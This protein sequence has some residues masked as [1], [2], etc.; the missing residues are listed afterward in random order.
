MSY[1]SNQDFS[2]SM[3]IITG[4]SL[5][6]ST[7]QYFN[8]YARNLYSLNVKDFSRHLHGAMGY[9]KSTVDDLA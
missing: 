7:G 4:Q 5:K 3:A 1:S 2:T 8:R 6:G 9:K